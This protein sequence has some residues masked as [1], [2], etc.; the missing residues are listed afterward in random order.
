MAEAPSILVAGRSGRLA[1]ALIEEALRLDLTVC[2]LGRPQLDIE[3]PASVQCV[4]AAQSPRAI[5]NAAGHVVVDEAERHPDRAFAVNR[6]GAAHLAAAASQAG[7][8]F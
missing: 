7:I 3:D 1:R 5:I 6:D 2:A 4:V 8:P